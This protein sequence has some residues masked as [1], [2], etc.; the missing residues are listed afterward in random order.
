MHKKNKP[1]AA[2]L[3]QIRTQ[4]TMEQVCQICN[5]TALQYA[6]SQLYVGQQYIH[7]MAFSTFDANQLEHNKY[8]WNWFKNQWL[9]RDEQFI[10]AHHLLGTMAI[11]QY[12]ILEAVNYNR[13]IIW[14]QAHNVY[15]LTSQL[16]P[17]GKL[18]HAA[19]AQFIGELFDTHSYHKKP[20]K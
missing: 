17:I 6:E 11:N 3:Y 15:T 13:L 8:Y 9:L 14:Q 19:Y 12:G 2:E 4:K 20:N 18:M 16:E 5:I 10:A 1:T 7:I